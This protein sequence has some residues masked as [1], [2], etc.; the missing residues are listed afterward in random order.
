MTFS[1]VSP[2]LTPR[3]L[4]DVTESKICIVYTF[5]RGL[6]VSPIRLQAPEVIMSNKYH[7]K[8]DLWSVGTIIFQCFT[9]KAPFV[10]NTPQ[11][12][13]A[14]YEK[15]VNLKPRYL[16]LLVCQSVDTLLHCFYAS[17]I[18]PVHPISV[19]DFCEVFLPIYWVSV[20]NRPLQI[21]FLSERQDL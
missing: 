21:F 11:Q 1:C 13:R 10:A 2:F 16:L 14:F 5:K 4:L 6:P 17:G 15:N 20:C 19:L 9:G 18:G 8:A 12:L 7:F 3:F